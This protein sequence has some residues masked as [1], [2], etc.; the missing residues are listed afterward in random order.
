MILNSGI[1]KLAVGVAMAVGL[2]IGSAQA[3]INEILVDGVGTT[4]GSVDGGG[5]GMG[6]LFFSI[7]DST[8]EKSLTL[9]LNIGVQEFLANPLAGYSVQNDVLL[10]FITTGDQ[11]AMEWNVGGLNNDTSSSPEGVFI[12]TT[13]DPSESPLA[14]DTINV[15]L[16]GMAKAGEYIA[17]VNPL[18]IS[19]VAEVLATDNSKAYWDGG[20]WRDDF[21][22]TLPF[23]NSVEVANAETAAMVIIGF[24]AS[25]SASRIDSS[26]AALL[27]EVWRL[28]T[29]TGTVSFGATPIPVPA[30]AWLLGSAL[31]GLYRIHRRK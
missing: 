28:D 2:G 11:A 24:N 13:V 15:Q 3:A 8:N 16:S 14:F 25:V 31:V 27:S 12:V 9:D 19:G 6:E 4:P 22:G 29:D 18:L 20:V 5:A 1:R 21:G 7:F 26:N 17:A 10:N 23:S 30:A